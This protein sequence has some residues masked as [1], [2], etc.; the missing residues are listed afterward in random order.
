[1]RVHSVECITRNIE[2]SFSHTSLRFILKYLTLTLELYADP[3]G[4]FERR[5]T[6]EPANAGNCELGDLRLI[7]F[8]SPFG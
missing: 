6:P 2:S 8:A 3:E 4:R 5:K 7:L 1:M